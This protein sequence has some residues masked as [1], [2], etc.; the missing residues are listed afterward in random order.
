MKQA[1]HVEELESRRMLTST[2]DL[3]PTFGHDGKM[4]FAA[5]GFAHVQVESDGKAIVAAI[6][7]GDDGPTKLTLARVTKQGALDS[8]FGNRGLVYTQLSGSEK[9]ISETYIDSKGR[10]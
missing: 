6:K 7:N 4:K 2:W 10:I 3:D 8:T 1:W 9:R 5:D